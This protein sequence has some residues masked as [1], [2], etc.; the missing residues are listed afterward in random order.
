MGNSTSQSIQRFLSNDVNSSVVQQVIQRYATETS[1][2][3]TNTQA[4]KWTLNAGRTINL[5]ANVRQLITSYID[6]QNIIDRSDKTALVDDLRTAVTTTLDDALNKATDGL[7]GF[8]QNPSN[9]TLVSDVRNNISTYV[10]QT[11][12]TSTIDQLLLS[13]SNIQNGVLDLTAGED[14][15]GNLQWNQTIQSEVM[16]T[17]IIKQ[18]VDNAL[19]N[20]QVQDLVTKAS[21]N[22]TV[23]EK[24]PITTGVEAIAGVAKSLLNPRAIIL[25]VAIVLGIVIAIAAIAA[26]FFITVPMKTR[27]IIGGAGVAVGVIVIIA[28][29]IYYVASAPKVK[30]V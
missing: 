25:I 19:Q 12:N 18:V 23:V 17:N 11:I 4:L 21:G 8:L 27:Y 20:T 3:S 24:S 7:A 15:N 10:N 1:A 22:L 26:A 2:V 9:Q 13:S 5:N 14:I 28:G 29:I 6:V 16:A 30:V